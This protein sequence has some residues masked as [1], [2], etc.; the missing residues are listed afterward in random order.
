MTNVTQPQ[1]VYCGVDG[2]TRTS[3]D[4]PK[5]KDVQ[6]YVGGF[7]EVVSTHNGF[8][9]VNEEGRILDLPINKEASKKLG[10]PIVGNV[11][12]FENYR[13]GDWYE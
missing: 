7:V 4:I 5:F 2:Q 8:A 6:E 11:V 10:L 1:V 9:C 13:Q 3:A 12:I